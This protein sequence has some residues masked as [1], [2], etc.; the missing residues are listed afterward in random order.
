M[1]DQLRADPLLGQFADSYPNAVGRAG[2][3]EEIAAV[4]GFVLSDA[5]SLMIGSVVYAD[6]G[7]DAIL[8]PRAPEGWEI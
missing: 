7:T 3:P 4:I 5:G 8:H 1:T 6:G 2:R